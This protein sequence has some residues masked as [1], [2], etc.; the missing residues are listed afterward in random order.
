MVLIRILDRKCSNRL[1][2]VLKIMLQTV[3]E[4][5]KDGRSRKFLY[6]NTELLS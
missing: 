3:Q 6:E 4:L 2:L 5:K 1:F